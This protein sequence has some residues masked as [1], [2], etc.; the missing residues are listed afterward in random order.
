[1]SNIYIFENGT[2]KRVTVE[3]MFKT[4]G[5]YVLEGRRL[6]QLV[7]V[8]I[9]HDSST[10]S[11]THQGTSIDSVNN[12]NM[13]KRAA[14]GG[15]LIGGVG[16]AIGG[17][18]AQRE[19]TINTV[20]NTH[21]NTELTAELIYADGTSQYVLLDDI[22]PFHWLLSC[23]NQKPLTDEEVESERLAALRE[24]KGLELRQ[25]LAP[26]VELIFLPPVFAKDKAKQFV[27]PVLVVI[28]IILL[29][30]MTHKFIAIIIIAVLICFGRN[31]V[32]MIIERLNQVSDD[33]IEKRFTLA[34]H[35]VVNQAIALNVS[36]IRSG[37][38][39]FNPHAQYTVL[40]NGLLNI[41]QRAN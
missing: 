33:E 34:K 4:H 39:I 8:Q 35:D 7:R 1:M 21:I 9:I 37:Q 19:A 5:S 18:T 17:I 24:Q 10:S 40:D 41:K 22:K 12:L 11:Q 13:L 28:S 6:D 31:I 36:N 30:A 27:I 32:T 25:I 2:K 14:V 16:A 20:T 15:V 23:V 29:I 26:T 3:R 38:I